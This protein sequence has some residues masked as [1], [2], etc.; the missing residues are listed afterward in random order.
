MRTYTLSDDKP[1][2]NYGDKVAID[3]SFFG[4]DLGILPGRIVGRGFV[5][6]IDH[7]IIEFNTD[8]APTYPYRALLIPHTAIIK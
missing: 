8:F 7:W 3:S 1:K 2:F 6:V 5:H 4:C